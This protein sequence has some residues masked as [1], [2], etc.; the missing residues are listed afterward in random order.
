[1]NFEKWMQKRGNNKL[2]KFAKNPYHVSWIKRLPLWSK[3]AVPT[4]MAATAAI[5]IITVG[6]LPSFNNDTKSTSGRS[7]EAVSTSR[8]ASSAAAPEGQDTSQNKSSQASSAA[9]HSQASSSPNFY[10][11]YN[12]FN[13]LSYNNQSYGIVS[14]NKNPV[15]VDA[16]YAKG[17]IEERSYVSHETNSFVKVTLYELTYIDKEYAFAVKFAEDYHYYLYQSTNYVGDVTPQ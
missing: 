9:S 2:N 17:I 6:V 13:S 4:L 7:Q 1:M 16:K 12:E 15:T 10:P 8:V 3:V 11:Y 5:V 14:K